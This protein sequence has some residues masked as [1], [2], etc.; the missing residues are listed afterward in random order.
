VFLQWL[1]LETVHENIVI[2]TS[3]FCIYDR[4]ALFNS[5]LYFAHNR[6]YGPIETYKT[7]SS[8]PAS[9]RTAER[10]VEKQTRFV[11]DRS[12]FFLIST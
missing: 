6:T 9:V 1:G 3:Q 2:F 5:G 7:Y 11:N 10:R 4:K 8:K 12:F